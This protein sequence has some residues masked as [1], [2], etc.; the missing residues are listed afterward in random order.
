MASE[1]YLVTG[2]LGCIGSW[3]VK[4]L[5]DEN[6][7]VWTYDLPGN[8]HRLRLIMS[9]DALSKVN[10]ISADITDFAAFE[11]AVVDNGIT[12]IIH[13]A[14]LQ[15]PFVKADPIR[16]AQVNVVGTT[17]VLET[18]KRHA[19]QVYNVAYASSIAVYGAHAE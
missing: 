8:P 19:D 2:A 6:F 9:D 1:R 17:I 14:A 7:P 10:F 4:R 13:L 15:F 5:V 16:G 11:R 18:A 3:T 12:H